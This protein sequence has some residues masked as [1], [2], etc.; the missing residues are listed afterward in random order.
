MGVNG[1][2]GLSGSGL[3]I[4]SMV[5]VGMMA[6]Q[7]E[8]DKMAQRYTKNEWTK[9]AY[10]ELSSSINTFKNSTLTTY[11]RQ[12]NMNAKEAETSSSAIKVSATSSAAVMNHTVEVKGL[13]A[14]AYLIGTNKMQR[15]AITSNTVDNQSIKLADVLFSDLT[16][17]TKDDGKTYV[18]GHVA[19]VTAA[20]INQTASD[21]NDQTWGTQYTFG[22]TTE[23]YQKVL[24]SGDSEYNSSSAYW[25]KNNGDGT[26]TN[27][28]SDIDPTQSAGTK[29]SIGSFGYDYVNQTWFDPSRQEEYN[30]ALE[31]WQARTDYASSNG[32]GFEKVIDKQRDVST[33]GMDEVAFSFMITDGTK[34]ISDMTDAEKAAHTISYTYDQLLNGG[35][36]LTDLASDIKNLGLNITASYDVNRD[37]FTL[38]NKESGLA[39]T[40]EISIGSDTSDSTKSRA[41]IVARN[42][43]TNLGLYQ[44]ENGTLKGNTGGTAEVGDGNSLQ[45]SLN[46]TKTVTGDDNEIVIDGVT[47]KEASNKI[48]VGGVTYTALSKTTGATTVTISQDTDAIIDRVKSFVS[49]YNKILGELYA[50]YDEK[51]DSNYKPLTQSQ[52]DAMKE[53]QITKWEEKAKQ[54]LLYH[55][56]TLGRVIQNLRSSITQSVE[57][58][59]GSTVSIFNIGISTTGLKGQLSL[60]E[61]KLKKALD[62]DPEIVSKV[63]T[64]LPESEN[65]LSSSEIAS[66]SGVAQRLSDNFQ[67][68]LTNIKSRAGSTA[69]ITE[70]S[71]L[72][73]LMRN[74]Q[75]RMSSFK[76]MMASFEESLYK[77]Y[78]AMESTLARLGAQLSYITGSTS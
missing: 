50:K 5:K 29:P 43:F 65:G 37:Q 76:K 21:G 2:Y 33:L 72:N 6:K 25:R 19:A 11:T 34:K 61:D 1:I 20:G 39:N 64:V 42:F 13:S 24:S 47:Y 32:A 56:Q 14:N 44:S 38:F 63:F 10:L 71:D 75:T 22:K 7:S 62:N 54:G 30:K 18:R 45:F 4:E 35:K 36:T 41:A 46:K 66:K 78:D 15:A 53:E 68:A 59:D 60:D 31:T 8:Y 3:D 12:S 74:L 69:D 48:T 70:D 77:K 17:Q 58:K 55:D 49:D 23:T 16:K 51:A 28:S 40:I 26:Y 57:Q 73:N 9:S 52:K 67:T 27:Y